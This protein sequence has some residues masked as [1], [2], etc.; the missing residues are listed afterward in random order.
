MW[1]CVDISSSCF[2]C[3]ECN[4][5]IKVVQNY[6][7][8]SVYYACLQVSVFKRPGSPITFIFCIFSILILV[9]IHCDFHITTVNSAGC[10]ALLRVSWLIWFWYQRMHST[11]VSMSL[12]N[13]YHVLILTPWDSPCSSPLRQLAFMD[14]AHSTLYDQVFFQ[15]FI[16]L[17]YRHLLCSTVTNAFIKTKYLVSFR[18]FYLLI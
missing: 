3:Y 7:P 15:V 9:Y 16:Q 4:C 13:T 12:T 8:T 11:D 2:S 18:Y 17:I 1:I 14:Y 10:S 5:F 6:L